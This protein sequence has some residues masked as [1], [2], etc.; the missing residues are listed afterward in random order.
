ML[1]YERTKARKMRDGRYKFQNPSSKIKI[2]KENKDLST[3]S[4]YGVWGLSSTKYQIQSCK[5]QAP[6]P[7]IKN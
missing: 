7:R 4:P 2:Q 5:T 3:L 1:I 6:K